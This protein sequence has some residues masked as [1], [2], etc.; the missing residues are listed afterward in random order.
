VKAPFLMLVRVRLVGAEHFLHFVK[1]PVRDSPH[2]LEQRLV[3][4]RPDAP[5]SL[6]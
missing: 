1:Q 5:V 4:V 2:I 3:L 6:G